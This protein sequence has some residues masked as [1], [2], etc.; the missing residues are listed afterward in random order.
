M[1]QLP[2][3]GCSTV[4][5]LAALDVGSGLLHMLASVQGLGMM[6]EE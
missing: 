3:E 4:C 5:N 2:Q 1:S 6:T